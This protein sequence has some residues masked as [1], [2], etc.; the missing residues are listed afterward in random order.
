MLPFCGYHMGDYFQHWIDLGDKLA[1]AS[2]R[3]PKIFTVNWFRTDDNGK[4]VWPG[5]GENMRVL[6]WMIDRIE[7]RAG[8]AEHLFGVSPRY[9]DIQWTGLD[10]PRA[11]Y[12]RITAIDAADWRKEVALH[13]E[14][15]ARLAPRLPRGLQETRSALEQ[16][17]GG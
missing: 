7:G 17:L 2:A 14:L 16:R 15:F 5:F 1:A 10:F 12:E 13:G 6:K 8:G 3:L 9:E 4:F 11:S